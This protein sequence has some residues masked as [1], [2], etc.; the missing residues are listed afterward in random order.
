M[1]TAVRPE[2]WTAW[3]ASNKTH[4]NQPFTNWCRAG[5]SPYTEPSQQFR[6]LTQQTHLPI[7]LFLLVFQLV[8]EAHN[9]TQSIDNET[10]ATIETIIPWGLPATGPYFYKILFQ[11]IFLVLFW[12]VYYCIVRVYISRRNGLC[13]RLNQIVTT[14]PLKRPRALF[15]CFTGRIL[16]YGA[17]NMPE[18]PLLVQDGLF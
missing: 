14:N 15:C 1:L 8:I 4:Q 16:P 12:S 10:P 2:S 9:T 17:I 11:S 3:L 7:I 5:Y 13:I 6:E 18:G